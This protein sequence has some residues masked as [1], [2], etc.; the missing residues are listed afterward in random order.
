[1][2]MWECK[3]ESGIVTEGQALN[4]AICMDTASAVNL[5]LWVRAAERYHQAAEACRGK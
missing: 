1:M 4:T 5:G 2:I 3:Y